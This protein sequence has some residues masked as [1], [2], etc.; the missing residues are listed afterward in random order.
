MSVRFL[1]GWMMVLAWG[2]L[3]A[4]TAHEVLEKAREK[5]ESLRDAE[6]KF[7]QVTRFPLSGVEQRSKGLLQMKKPNC[8]RIESEDRVVVTD[9]K[10][11]WS[12]SPANNQVLIDHFKMDEGAFS[13]DR[14][15]SAAPRDYASTL[16]GEEKLGSLQAYVVKLLPSEDGS[17]VKSMKLWIATSDDLT[18]KVE[19]VDANG[20][21]TTYTVSDLRTN[22]GLP[23]G[24]FVYTP[25]RGADVVDLR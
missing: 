20:K 11:V 18:R 1:V 16:L 10:T 13:P 9:G 21:E 19:I 24:R 5:F 4:Q 17:F 12:Y 22:I 23:D 8:Y 2:L 25:P 3:Q 14:I 6:L 15:L 7:V